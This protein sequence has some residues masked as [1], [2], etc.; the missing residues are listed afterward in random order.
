MN[1]KCQVFTPYNTVVVLLDRVGY[2]TNLYGKKVIENA[3]GDGNILREIVRRYIV[4]SISNKI[5]IEDI[6]LGLELDIC[7]IE[8]DNNHY[9]KCIDNINKVV[10]EYDIYNVKWNILNTDILKI[11]LEKKFDYVIGNPPYIA[12]QDLDEATR[13]FVKDNFE[14]CF[15]GKFDYC[16]AFIEASLGCL[17]D[18]GKISYL[19]P[20]NIFKN[21]FADKLREMMLPYLTK[22]Y[23]YTVQKLFDKALTS[24]AILIFDKANC[25]DEILYFDISKD[26]SYEVDKKSLTGKWIF[27]KLNKNIRTNKCKFG[28][29]FTASMSVATLLNEAFILTNFKT[30]EYY[31]IVNDSKVE[32]NV[33]RKAASPR[34]LNYNKQELIIFPYYYKNGSLC[35]Y[36]PEVFET[37]FPEAASYLQKFSEKLKVRKADQSAQW[38]EYGRSQALAHI[39]QDKLLTST[40]VT[41][42][43]KVYKLSKEYIPYSGIYI[44]SKGQMPLSLAKSILESQSFFEYVKAIGTNASG[45]S[46]RITAVDINNYE[47]Q[48][49]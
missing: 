34:S 37:S 25:T 23:D 10:A 17:N 27:S 19:I 39:N 29:H 14:S 22:I 33:V 7:G 18:T 20:S 5:K 45:S 3:C 6:K 12:Y 32:L 11:K 49:R 16:Y 1:K 4:D 38:Y 44:T 24:S 46:I 9:L 21:V 2:T 40:V 36:T 26:E 35:R 48:L 47:F 13:V 15:N 42:H 43:V 30:N 8:I 41:K 28:D 31:I